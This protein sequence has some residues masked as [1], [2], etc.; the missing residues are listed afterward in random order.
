MGG[1]ANYIDKRELK[2]L[3]VLKPGISILAIA[4][5]WAVIFAAIGISKW[6]SHPLAY[7]AAIAIIGSRQHALG[8]L[9][10]EATHYRLTA[11][12]AVN[13]WIGDLLLAWP[14]TTTVD[15]YRRNH[16]EHHKHANTERDPDWV[17]KVGRPL[18]TFPQRLRTALLHLGGYLL[19]V[20]SIRDAILISKRVSTDTTKKRTIGYLAVRV[21]VHAALAFVFTWFGL[22]VDF[23]IYW[24][25][26]FLSFFFFFLYIRSVAE[27]FGNMDYTNELGGTRTVIA[28]GLERF[29]FSPHQV[30]YH[31]EHHLFPGVPYY[32]LPELHTLLMQSPEYAA[33]AHITRGYCTGLAGECLGDGVGLLPNEPMDS[34]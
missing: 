29:V 16:L 30:N 20:N 2:R 8:T 11:N 22:W 21:A 14:I 12:K 3:S 24:I 17:A 31:L 32:N 1:K 7:L 33:N 19:F 27:H 15:S 18:F 13:D 10:H 28:N 5:D 4:F 9:L 23:L 6:L 26:P 25:V 34:F